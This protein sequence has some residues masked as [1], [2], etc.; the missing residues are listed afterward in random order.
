M[1]VPIDSRHEKTGNQ[2]RENSAARFAP[3]FAGGTSSDRL[4]DFRR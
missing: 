1:N 3:G 4:E 2:D